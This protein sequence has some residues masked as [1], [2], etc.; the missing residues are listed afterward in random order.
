MAETFNPLTVTNL[1][2]QTSITA[3]ID[4]NFATIATLL[5]DVLSRAG[6]TPNTMSSN[7]DMNGNRIVNLGAPVSGSDAARLEDVT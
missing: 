2:N 4:A 7:L 1:T 3:N 6:N 5:N